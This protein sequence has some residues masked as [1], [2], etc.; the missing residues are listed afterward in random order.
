MGINAAG[1]LGWITKRCSICNR[2]LLVGKEPVYACPKCS[3]IR[4]AHFCSGDYKV[5]HGKCPYCGS[6]LIPVL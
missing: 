6:E 4:G 3:K 2:R 5:L 1:H